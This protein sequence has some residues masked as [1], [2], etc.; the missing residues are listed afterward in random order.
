MIAAII[1]LYLF[2]AV[3]T[4]VTGRT[5]KD[6]IRSLQK[7]SGRVIVGALTGNIAA[8]RQGLYEGGTANA[9]FEPYFGSMI[10]KLGRAYIDFPVCPAL[11]LA[12]NMGSKEHLNAAAFLIRNGADMNLYKLPSD[13]FEDKHDRGYPP[14]YNVRS[15]AGSGSRQL[16]CGSTTATI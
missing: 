8:I 16:P 13:H 14:G 2:L 12:I 9:I 10:L 7:S 11:H 4:R 1:K 5:I 15:R 6:D 3:F